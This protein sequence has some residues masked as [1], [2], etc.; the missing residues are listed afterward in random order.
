MRALFANEVP[1]NEPAY[2]YRR[3]TTAEGYDTMK[4]DLMKFFDLGGNGKSNT[5]KGFRTIERIDTDEYCFL[6][7]YNGNTTILIY[8]SPIDKHCQMDIIVGGIE[9]FNDAVNDISINGK[10]GVAKTENIIISDGDIK[11]INGEVEINGVTYNSGV[12]FTTGYMK[13]LK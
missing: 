13:N 8:D 6:H 12:H 3:S 5:Y 2:L 7:L 11:S 9:T 1:G 4:H 10:K